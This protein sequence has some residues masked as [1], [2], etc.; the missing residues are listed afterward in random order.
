M[1]NT[2]SLIL[3]SLQVSVSSCD[4]L[5]VSVGQVSMGRAINIVQ[6]F[7]T[8]GIPAE[9]MYDWSQVEFLSL[10]VN[11]YYCFP[12]LVQTETVLSG[13]VFLEA[14][15][16]NTEHVGCCS[17]TIMSRKFHWPCSILPEYL[18]V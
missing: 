8:A 10:C 4:L 2:V 9:I 5:V 14:E 12:R 1:S 7:W 17:D 3:L 11:L 6:K 18:Y 16:H 13:D 15:T